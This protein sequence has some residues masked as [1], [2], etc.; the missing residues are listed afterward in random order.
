MDLDYDEDRLLAEVGATRLVGE[1]DYTT[2]E[3]LWARPTLDVNGLLGG[4]TGEGAKTV[5]PA[6]AMAKVSMRLVPYQKHHAA[7]VLISL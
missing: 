1:K 2:P 7:I 6:R 3:Q 5:L 4:F